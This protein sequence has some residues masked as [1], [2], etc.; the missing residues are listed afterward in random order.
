LCLK[1]NLLEP[2][3]PFTQAHGNP[4]I[5]PHWEPE[6]IHNA[7][8]RALHPTSIEHVDSNNGGRTLRGRGA[9]M[10]RRNLRCPRVEGS[11]EEGREGALIE[12]EVGG[13][14]AEVED[15]GFKVE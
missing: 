3:L 12:C 13:E 6:T 15:E 2:Q 14:A 4:S 7:L 5:P 1:S 10:T 8:S 11:L 9:E